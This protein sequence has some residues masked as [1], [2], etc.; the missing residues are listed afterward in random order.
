MAIPLKAAQSMVIIR[1]LAVRAHVGVGAP[2]RRA[3]Q[4]VVVDVEIRLADPL[5][6]RDHMST[7]INYV[8]V[9]RLIEDT[10]T[11]ERSVLLETLADRIASRIFEDARVAE[12]T[13][14]IT[15]P[16]KIPNCAAGGIQRTFRREE[17][18]HGNT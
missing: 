17:A 18:P 14:T 10:C 11:S 13:L 7:S 4:T 8:T 1:G 16:R 6:A 12:V 3:P 15:K 2:E 9:V 5:I